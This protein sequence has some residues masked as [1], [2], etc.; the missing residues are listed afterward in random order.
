MTLPNNILVMLSLIII[1]ASF[2]LLVG[3]IVY[4]ELKLIILNNNTVR[5]LSQLFSI[6]L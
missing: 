1:G 2:L 3:G 6:I 5:L 4:S